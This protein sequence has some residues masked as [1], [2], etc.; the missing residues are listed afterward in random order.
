[1]YS[2]ILIADQ[3]CVIVGTLII[4]G[5]STF[6]TS[7]RHNLSNNIVTDNVI[8]VYQNIRD[9]SVLCYIVV[10]HVIS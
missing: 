2:C 5:M 1:M 6:L 9:I 4:E 8:S 10:D 7:S 3:K